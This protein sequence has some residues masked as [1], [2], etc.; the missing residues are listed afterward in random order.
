MSRSDE[1]VAGLGEKL[2]VHQ[3]P[4]D[5]SRALTL[6]LRDAAQRSSI[7]LACRCSQVDSETP[8]GD[9]GFQMPPF[10]LIAGQHPNL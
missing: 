9:E 6:L 7:A 2:C 8:Q 1:W 3:D 10:Q 4:F 5:S